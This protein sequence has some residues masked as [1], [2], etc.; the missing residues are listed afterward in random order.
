MPAEDCQVVVNARGQYSVM[1]AGRPSPAGWAAVD[2]RGPRTACLDWIE[3]AARR[4]SPGRPPAAGP[5]SNSPDPS[6]GQVDPP[7]PADLPMDRPKCLLGSAGYGRVE[8]LLPGDLLDAVRELAGELRLP[9]ETVFTAAVH[10]L[11]SRL[12]GDSAVSVGF[13]HDGWLPATRLDLS[14]V[15]DGRSAVRQT[16][17]ETAAAR[18]R[19]RAP[20]DGLTVRFAVGAVPAAQPLELVFRLEKR[21]LT[22]EYDRAMFD[23]ATVAGFARNAENL[24]RGMA[25][26]PD[27]PV[28]ALPLLDAVE[29]AAA[30]AAGSRVPLRPPPDTVPD[31]FAAV[32][33]VHADRP[34]LEGEDLSLTY[35]ELAHMSAVVADRLRDRGVGAGD[36]V[37]VHAGRSARVMVLLL[38]ILRVGAAFLPLDP[39]HPAKRRARMVAD[40]APALLVA[41]EHSAPPEGPRRTTL[42]ALTSE[43]LLAAS[44]EPA[45]GPAPSSAAYVIFTSGSTGDP[46]G[47]CNIHTG[48][49]NRLLWMQDAYPIGPDDAVLQKTPLTFDVS[50]WEVFWPLITGARLVVARR[51]GHRDP[52]Y[53]GH[54]IRSSGVTVVHFVP[55]MLQAMLRSGEL[56]DTPSVRHVICSG[57]ALSPQLRAQFFE[58]CRARLHNLYGPTEAA[59]DVTSY[60]CSPDRDPDSVPIG[61]PISGVSVHVLGPRLEPLPPGVVGEIYIGGHGLAR[62]YAGKPGLTAERFVAD[63]HGAPGDRLYR[64]GDLGRRR[65]DGLVEFL[66]RA[67]HQMALHGFRIEPGEI[68]AVATAVPGVSRAVVLPRSADSGGTVLVGFVESEESDRAALLETVRET[69]RETLPEYMRPNVWHV[70]PEL[71]TLDS[72]KTDRAA[73]LS[74]G[75]P[76]PA[77]VT[78][79]RPWTEREGRLAEVWQEVLGAPPEGLD[80]DFF[81][82][83]GDSILSIEFAASAQGAGLA[84]SA[85]DLAD[86]PTLRGLAETAVPVPAE[87]APDPQPFELLTDAQRSALP[88]G[89]EDAYPLSAVLAGL[90]HASET[91]PGYRV[92]TTTLT[93]RGDFDET[94]FRGAVDALVRRTPF[95]RTS[96]D[97]T[98][99]GGPV[100]IVHPTVPDAVVVTDL[101]GHRDAEAEFARHAAGRER[102]RFDWALPP[103]FALDVHRMTD[104]EFRLTLT[105]PMLDGWS[106]TVALATLLELYL[107]P[108]EVVLPAPD[109][110]AIHARHLREEERALGD[111]R[112]RAR[113][114]RIVADAPV[115]PQAPDA[116]EGVRRKVVPVDSATSARLL[117]LAAELGVPLRSVL[118]AAHVQVVALVCGRTEVVTGV[119][120]HGRP[121]RPGGARTIGMFLN[122]MPLRVPVAAGTH[123]DL[124]RAVHARHLAA[125]RDRHLPYAR[126]LRD[127]GLTRPLDTVFNFT[128]FQPYR[129]WTGSGPL[130]IVGIEATDQTYHPLT[131]QFRQDVLT[132]EVGLTLEFTGSV[133]P[134]WRIDQVTGLYAAALDRLVADPDAPVNPLDRLLGPVPWGSGPAEAEDADLY[135][136][137]TAQAART[138]DAVALE[139][140]DVRFTY[141]DLEDTAGALAAK[142]SARGVRPGS[143][144]ALC[145]PRSPGY[146]AAVL[147]VLRAGAAYLPLDAAHPVERRESI[148][149]AAGPAAVMAPETGSFSIPHVPVPVLPLRAD[150]DAPPGCPPPTGGG[151]RPAVVVFTSGS[152]GRP[153]G[154]VLG[155]G[156]IANRL[157]WSAASAPAGPD[158]VF[159]LRTPVTFVD[160]IAELFDGLVRGVPTRIL[161]DGVTDPADL[162]SL[163]R[164]AKITRVTIVPTLLRELLRLDRA[165]DLGGVRI[166][167]LSGEP[168]GH[169]LA[170]MLHARFP[171]VV[172][173]NLYGSTEVCADVTVHTV[174][175]EDTA[176][177]PIGRA[178]P[179]VR[180]DVVHEDGG[181][182]PAG[183]PGE[184]MV[185]GVA[186]ADGYLEDPRLTADHFLPA[187]YGHGARWF[188]TGDLAIVRPDGVLHLLGRRDRQLKVRGV[189]IEPAEVEAVL[190]A[191]PGVLD[192]LVTQRRRNGR[193]LLVAHVLAVDPGL[194]RALREHAAARLHGAAVPDV[195]AVVDHWPRLPSGKIDVAALPV[196]VEG[197]PGPASATALERDIAALW[198]ARFGE[199]PAGPDL[200]A[201]GA[202]SL[203]V[204][205]L[206][207]ALSRHFA[208]PV[209]AADLWARPTVREQAQLVDELRNTP[210]GPRLTALATG[211]ES[212]T[213]VILPYAGGE[214]GA[215]R[216]LA[217]AIAGAGLPVRVLGLEPGGDADPARLAAE[218]RAAATGPIALL[219]HC[220]GAPVAVATALALD[221]SGDAPVHV[222]A[223]AY[224]LDSTDPDRCTATR[225]AAG[226]DTAVVQW[227]TECGGLDLTGLA[228]DERRGLVRAFRADSVHA[229]AVLL[230]LLRSRRRL[231]CPLTVI[232][233]E[234]DKVIAGTTRYA[235]RWDLLAE[236]V[237]IVSTGHGG[238]HLHVT[239]PK[240]LTEAIAA[241]VSEA[242]CG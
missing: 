210:R 178:L 91:D 60:D 108:D 154:V 172:I 125:L 171:G 121:E 26:A 152:T 56:A 36:V 140:E 104:E 211:G 53:L 230:T 182:V 43:A 138:P 40:A 194:G 127:G 68:E 58:T 94:R 85:A 149:S 75:T 170:Q 146:V 165:G 161:P 166:W 185:G 231:G 164:D 205:L 4:A 69:V 55:S 143:V 28:E 195:V 206:A 82:A 212:V 73:L 167:Q 24:L 22:V 142:L 25:T 41:D 117:R 130:R 47:V 122:T 126:M 159:L 30:V 67:D 209:A 176:P 238:H 105:E 103:L 50:V 147:A 207:G 227:L 8:R 12:S 239:R 88:A 192:A 3:A 240:F 62:G 202:N 23:K 45:P 46:K 71:P 48:L 218:I 19:R 158:E 92:Y 31:L 217:D 216:P 18:M 27:A 79:D 144:V 220:A 21:L 200:I 234:D 148:L 80:T 155:H 32:A 174:T 110:P 87:S 64:T 184:I 136:L 7:G 175:G 78:P 196:P 37:A 219:G 97:I 197:E 114:A 65:R 162:V 131:A 101:R 151:G 137:F 173:R 74:L 224:I 17:A 42:D 179:G 66:G 59:I 95:L 242:G 128:H 160:A 180:I 237:R 81:Q 20:A 233:A 102:R 168:L 1:P 191:H 113:W 226:P 115:L 150:Q 90:V 120:A 214:A 124:V 111:D 38:A 222:F 49:A 83:G 2:V 189:R 93:L 199:A 188:R 169:D 89:V 225:I 44:A 181:R 61:A 39:D 215:Y 86:S 132:G 213:L 139:Y 109:E 135:G 203:D 123:R 9:T 77:T 204:M 145:L 72:G 177:V 119:M 6:T 52:A 99:P 187:P 13:S 35:A 153:K 229:D 163:I 63:P 157:R 107:D 51:E 129:R 183:T 70:L 221:E 241:A 10:V 156:A 133:F 100:Q 84:V 208:V 16:G 96:V 57:E 11:L 186:L 98:L 118:L 235:R 5:S 15:R 76:A 193:G 201:L 29:A 228:E 112:A 232:Y 198:S 106:V 223:L 190:M 116:V 33:A 134:E 34:A 141:R 14:T 54:V 236:H